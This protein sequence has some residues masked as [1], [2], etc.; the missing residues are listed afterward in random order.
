LREFVTALEGHPEE[1][2]NGYLHRGDFSRWIRDVFG[3][4]ALADELRRHEER[5]RAGVDPDSVPEITASI[6]ARY[7][8]TPGDDDGAGPAVAD[9]V[10]RSKVA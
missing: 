8:L 10:R 1:A 7:D 2:L 3:D 6:R 4:R 9:E 5:Y